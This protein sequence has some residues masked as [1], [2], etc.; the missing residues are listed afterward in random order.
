M[1]ERLESYRDYQDRAL[2]GDISALDEI[3]NIEALID[4]ADIMPAHKAFLRLRFIDGMKTKEIAQTLGFS[5]KYVKKLS[6]K[7]FRKIGGIVDE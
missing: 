1:R 4:N 7:I 3:L 2:K 5:V 6:Y